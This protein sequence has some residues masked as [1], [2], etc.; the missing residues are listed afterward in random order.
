VFRGA[1]VGA[2]DRVFF[3]FSFGPFIGF[4]SAWEGTRQVGALAISGGGQ[5]SVQRLH[6]LLETEATVICCTPSY[7]LHLAEVARENG[8]DIAASSVQ[9]LIVAGEPG[10]NIPGTRRRIEEAWGAELFDHTGATEVGAHGFECQAHAGVHLNEGEFIVEVINPATGQPTDE[11]E[12]VI[13]NLGRVGM[14]VIRYRTGDQVRLTWESCECGRTFAR[15][16]GG[17]IGRIDDMLIVRGVNIFPSAIENI[18]RSF[19]EVDEFAIEVFKRGEMDELELKIEVVE[20]EPEAI[21][22]A[23]QAELERRLSLRV[24]VHLAPPGSLPRW[25]LKARRVVDRRGQ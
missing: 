9:R 10:A 14:P 8:L 1:G 20:G 4:W 25:E 3:A 5:S 16:E 17:I 24:P 13:T 21:A 22:R 15:M 19:P 2:G 11:G 7:A 18:V 6:H 12:L 23:V